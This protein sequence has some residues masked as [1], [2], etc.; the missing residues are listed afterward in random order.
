MPS[1]LAALGSAVHARL[2]PA[3]RTARVARPDAARVANGVADFAVD[4]FSPHGVLDVRKAPWLAIAT[5]PAHDTSNE[6][7]IL[8]LEGAS[9][10]VT[11]GTQ[12]VTATGDGTTAVW[13]RERKAQ[14]GRVIG[15]SLVVVTL[16][17]AATL[18]AE[19]TFA[20]VPDALSSFVQ[21]DGC[22]L[23]PD[24]GPPDGA[25]ES[26]NDA[27]ADVTTGDA[28][29]A[30]I[31]CT[32]TSDCLSGYTLPCVP[33]TGTCM[34]EWGKTGCDPA[35]AP[36]QAGSTCTNGK[37]SPPA[38]APDA[39]AAPRCL[40]DSDC[41][42]GSRCNTQ[43][44]QC[45]AVADADADA[46]ARCAA[47]QC[48]AVQTCAIDAQCGPGFMRVAGSCTIAPDA[49]GEV[50]CGP[51]CVDASSDPNNCGM[52]FNARQS[53]QSCAFGACI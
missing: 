40:V 13:P 16:G 46:G 2:L 28:G 19:G 7:L 49:G 43:T 3:T 30:P 8:S 45:V 42:G 39:G 23:L 41:S 34:L 29:P 14:D 21:V 52:R 33:T 1:S 17:A 38:S 53:G 36:C 18:T 15:T 32:S 44:R 20:A 11:A 31:A 24:P 9:A 6:S 50:A 25:V 26:G 48:R 37:R 47:G 4:H 35:V 12:S 5:L 22:K 51:A 27:A 10:T